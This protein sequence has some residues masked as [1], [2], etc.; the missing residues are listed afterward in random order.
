MDKTINSRI[1]I[2]TIN[3]KTLEMNCSDI[4]GKKIANHSKRETNGSRYM[5][6]DSNKL[7]NCT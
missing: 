4:N 7:M 6:I 2:N 5:L 3:L 1:G